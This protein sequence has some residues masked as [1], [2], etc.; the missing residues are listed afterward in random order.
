MAAGWM[1]LSGLT[2]YQLPPFAHELNPV[3]LV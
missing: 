2:V 1:Q 3:E